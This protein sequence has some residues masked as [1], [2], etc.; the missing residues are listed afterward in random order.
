MAKKVFD[1]SELLSENPIKA[2][3]KRIFSYWHPDKEELNKFDSFTINIF[4][5]NG[6]PISNKNKM[7]DFFHLQQANQNIRITIFLVADRNFTKQFE[8]DST[9]SIRKRDNLEILTLKK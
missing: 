9:F 3:P 7:R 8:N 1:L 5:D 6:K 2:E 4:P